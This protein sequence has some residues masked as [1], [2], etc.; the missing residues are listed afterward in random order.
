[1][2]TLQSLQTLQNNLT[3]QG[4]LTNTLYTKALDAL[5]LSKKKVSADTAS[6]SGAMA[7]NAV[8]TGGAT[9]AT[10]LFKKSIDCNRYRCNCGIDWYTDSKL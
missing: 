8:A 1:M 5:S 3:K 6:L 4:T 2:A 7:G 9:L 10:N